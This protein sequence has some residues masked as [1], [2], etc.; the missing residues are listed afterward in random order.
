MAEEGE[1]TYTDLRHCNS[2]ALPTPC[3]LLALPGLS[4]DTNRW[5]CLGRCVAHSR[6]RSMKAS[7]EVGLGQLSPQTFE[8]LTIFCCWK[9][10]TYLHT[11]VYACTGTDISITSADRKEKSQENCLSTCS[12]IILKLIQSSS[13]PICA[14]FSAL[15]WTPAHI[16]HLCS[17]P[18]LCLSPVISMLFWTCSLCLYF[19]PPICTFRV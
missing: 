1:N 7:H 16:S 2:N 18:V 10:I 9:I 14:Q 11:R 13:M 5:G 6:Y 12:S 3:C 4:C 17:N 8:V 15:L 19:L